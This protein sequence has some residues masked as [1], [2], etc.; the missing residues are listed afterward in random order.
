MS[1]ENTETVTR[2][3]EHLNRGAVEEVVELCEDDFLMH[4]TERVFN[5]DTYRGHDGIRRFYEG[6]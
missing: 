4:M 3:Y 2:I 5:P 6:A 1:Q